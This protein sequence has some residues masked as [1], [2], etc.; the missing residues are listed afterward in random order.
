MKGT[1]KHL[2]MV[3]LLVSVLLVGVIVL[4]GC[5]DD[6]GSSDVEGGQKWT[7]PDH[8]HVVDNRP[9][10]C[11]TCGKDLVPLEEEKAEEKVAE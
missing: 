6:S 2:V 10:R 5:K 9:V 11:R 3:C 1:R 8:P 7:C 4:Q